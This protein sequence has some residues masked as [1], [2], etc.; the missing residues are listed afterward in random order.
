VGLPE[1]VVKGSHDALDVP[2]LK[3]WEAVGADVGACE[4]S[5]HGPHTHSPL[6]MFLP[7]A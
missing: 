5:V 3:I 2:S 7:P 6:D 1:E 4:D